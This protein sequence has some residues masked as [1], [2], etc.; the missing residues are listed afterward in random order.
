MTAWQIDEAEFYELDSREQQLTF[1][2]RYAVL[3]PSTHNLQPWCFR[4]VDGGVEVY[5][6]S[7][8]RLPVTDPA[9]REL[10]M[11]IGAAITN[12]RVAAAHF[13]FDSSVLYQSRPEESVPVAMLSFRETCSPDRDLT[14]LFSAITRRHTNRAPFRSEPLRARQ[15]D[16]LFVVAGAFPTFLRFVMPA[17]RGRAASLVA[18]GDLEQHA[19]RGYREELADADHVDATEGWLLRH[20]D[21]G[22]LAARRDTRLVQQSSLLLV[23]A[24][25]DDRTSLIRAGEVL[26]RLLLTVTRLGLQYSFLNQPVEVSSLRERL[27]TLVGSTHPPQ[28]LIRIGHADPVRRAAARRELRSVLR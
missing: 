24:A 9:D 26:E 19:H 1:L 17:D 6:D 14:L 28:L 13:G 23:V 4:V 27:W 7:S 10:L 11:S 12:L 5:L 18:A 22:A 3:A 21:L 2:L 16:A 20:F 25:D 8:R 15:L